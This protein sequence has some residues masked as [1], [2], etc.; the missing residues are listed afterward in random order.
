[1][2]S[3]IIRYVVIAGA[4]LAILATG[5]YILNTLFN[6]MAATPYMQIFIIPI[7]A[8]VALM[9]YTL[10]QRIVTRELSYA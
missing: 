5:M 8:A 9:L 3:P 7:A 1:M 4:G 10:Y 6:Q 2:D